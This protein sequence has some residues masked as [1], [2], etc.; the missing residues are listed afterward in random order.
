MLGALDHNASIFTME[1]HVTPKDQSP[2]VYRPV[3]RFDV[4]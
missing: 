3:V 4:L 1:L 2:R